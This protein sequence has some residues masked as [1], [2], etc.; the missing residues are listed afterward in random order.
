MKKRYLSN[1]GL[2]ISPVIFGGNVF[3]WTINEKQSFEIL[4][5]FVDL[6]FDTIDTAD[7]YSGWAPGNSGG[8][9]EIIIGRWL[10][11][12]PGIRDKVKIFTKG[13]ADV[14]DPNAKGLS[15]KW[16]KQACEDSL[17]RLKTDHVDVYFSHFPD[18]DTPHEETL[19][20]YQDLID[21][22]KIQIL[23]ASNFSAK[24]LLDAQSASHS[25]G[26]Q[27]YQIIQPEYNLYDRNFFESELR[28]VSEKLNL[29]VVTY[30]SLAS[31]FLS[32]K[33][34]TLDSIKHSA[35]AE[36]LSKYF[37]QKG[38]EILKAIEK[39]SIKYNA[40]M[41]EIALAWLLSRPGVSAPIASATTP[42]QLASFKRATEL[43]LSDE[44]IKLLCDTGQ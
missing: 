31:G 18:D 2:N 1:T 28:A 9:S 21:S 39:T 32:G 25:S 20:A 22:G 10:N 7:V 30:Y 35:R 11:S 13:G 4:D 14:G 6:G 44:D 5:A 17:R 37:N 8:E 42:L 23:G 43:H 16:I 19:S 24:Q 33:Y 26:L 40:T 34:R 36:D 3:G 41:T 27:P 12:R 29:A 15:S 38:H